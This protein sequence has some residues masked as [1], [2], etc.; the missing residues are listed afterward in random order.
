MQHGTELLH[1]ITGPTQH[2]ARVTMRICA[3][4]RN[5]GHFFAPQSPRTAA[6]RH[7]HDRWDDTCAAGFFFFFFF[8][9]GHC[10]VIVPMYVRTLH[11]FLGERA[12]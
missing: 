6:A 11:I 1:A 10:V 12:S 7:D 8:F 3:L 4:R 9:Q 5:P 2:L